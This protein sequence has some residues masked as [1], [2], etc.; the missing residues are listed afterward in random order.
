MW[1][2]ARGLD[3]LGGLAA[4]L[5]EMD[6]QAGN[7]GLAATGDTLDAAGKPG[8]L[9]APALVDLLASA[10][11]ADGR[12]ARLRTVGLSAPL[13]LLPGATRYA[14]RRGR[15]GLPFHGSRRGG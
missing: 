5:E 12:T 15:L 9:I 11:M 4:A 13:F 2:A 8:A 10:A 3:P 6:G 7:G 14:L 1:L